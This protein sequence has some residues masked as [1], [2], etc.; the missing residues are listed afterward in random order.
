ME[1]KVT[2]MTD[3]AT[4]TKVDISAVRAKL[5][6]MILPQDLQ[7]FRTLGVVLACRPSDDLDFD[8]WQ[9]QGEVFL[10]IPIAYSYVVNHPREKVTTKFVNNFKAFVKGVREIPFATPQD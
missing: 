6:K 1:I 8:V 9:D 7:R 3:A 4:Q 10:T 5:L 2:S